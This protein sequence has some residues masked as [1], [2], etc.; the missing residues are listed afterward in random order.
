MSSS[1]SEKHSRSSKSGIIR[2]VRLSH[3]NTVS[4]DLYLSNALVMRRYNR[5]HSIDQDSKFVQD[6]A[7]QLSLP[8]IG[9]SVHS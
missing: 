8:L 7:E 3:L 5:L 2:P 6:V 4:L 1:I 9:V